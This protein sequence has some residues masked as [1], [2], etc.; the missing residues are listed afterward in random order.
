MAKMAES[1][2]LPTVDDRLPRG[3]RSARPCEFER[4][5]QEL[6]Q[7]RERGTRAPVGRCSDSGAEERLFPS[8]PAGRPYYLCNGHLRDLFDALDNV[9]AEESRQRPRVAESPPETST[10]G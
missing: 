6:V 4:A 2:D 1:G 9:R 3:G 7:P 5:Y 8:S 10:A